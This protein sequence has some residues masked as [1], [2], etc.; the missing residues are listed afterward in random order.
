[1]TT[2][3]H[4]TT[5]MAAGV[6]SLTLAGRALADTLD[7]ITKS[8]V[9]RVAVP[10]DLPPWG[11]VGPDMNLQGYDIDMAKLIAAK[12][13]VKLQMTPVTSENRIPY[14]QT[15]KVDLII[16][17]LGK[18]PARAK[19]IDFSD[20]Y[21]PFFSGVFGPATIDVKT[22]ADL[23]GK[24]IAVT[25]GN[26]EDIALS[27]LAPPSAQIMRYGDNQ[28]TISAFISGQTQLICTDSSTTATIMA[29]NPP[30][31]PLLKFIL[32]SSPCYVGVN[33]NQPALLAKVNAIIAA[34]KADGTLN[35]YCETWLKQPLPA[36]F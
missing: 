20:K 13:G 31:A 28:S 22:A 29:Q 23:A 2:R 19:V 4:F 24:S 21:A 17:S 16:S 32:Q 33:K 25:R 15:G 18:N 36:D 12:I 1:M 5:I 14:L 3:R 34:A 11:F 6:A 7:D 30:R 8:G 10:Q 27:K 35:K 26:I 9:L